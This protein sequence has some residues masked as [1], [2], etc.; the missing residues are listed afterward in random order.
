MRCNIYKDQFQSA[1][2]F[3]KPVLYTEK[4]IQR[5]DVPEA[6]Y[7]YDLTGTDREPDKPAA[8]EDR[9]PWNRIGSVLS[10]VSL[11]RKT[12]LARQ[13][14]NSFHLHE[15]LLDLAGFCE[16]NRMSCP[17]DPRKFILR[18]ASHE[19]A[20]QFYSL[21]D[22][23]EDEAAGTIGH[24]RMDFGG[25]RLHHSWW[26]H[27]DDRFNTPEF[28]AALQEFVD[29]LRSRGPLQS[30]AAMRRWCYG[31]PEGE[32]GRDH[33][34]FVAETEDY[35]FCLR[36]TTDRSDHSYI[37]CYDLNQ[38]RLAMGQTPQMGLTEQ[39][40]QRLKD[41]ADPRFP[42]SYSWYVMESCNTAY[43]AF[44]DGLSLEDAIQRYAASENESKRL[45]VTKDDIAAVDLLIRHD[46][47]EWVS[48]DW[49]KSESFAQDP[50]IADAAA[51]MRQ[52]LEDQT[53]NQSMTMGGMT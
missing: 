27:N 4:Q 34:G 5:E 48:E 49:T 26:P 20:G 16:K 37:Y 36:C 13:I 38:Q 40:Q 42:H 2:L 14:K 47:R 11:K 23:A 22:L 6:W 46:G 44:T 15:E 7:C 21:T 24:V 19:E 45:G 35:R 3:G 18:P 1:E 43:A 9:M 10:P 25:G 31:Y 33:V 12:T 41:T 50:T 39:G 8:L 32:T 17:Q 30:D 51:K 29:E 52:L 53:P 28:K